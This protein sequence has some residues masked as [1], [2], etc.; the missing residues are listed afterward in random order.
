MKGVRANK[1]GLSRYQYTQGRFS[2]TRMGNNIWNVDEM[3][4]FEDGGYDPQCL[5]H[6]GKDFPTLKEAREWCKQQ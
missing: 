3:G 4:E 1:I 2:I 5:T 6:V